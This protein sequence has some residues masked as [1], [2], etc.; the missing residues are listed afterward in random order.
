MRPA[1]HSRHAKDLELS[2]DGKSVARDSSDLARILVRMYH[3]GALR[4]LA[5]GCGLPLF[6]SVLFICP[7]NWAIGPGQ[8]LVIT[9]RITS[10]V[11]LLPYSAPIHRCRG[12]HRRG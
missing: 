10:G 11:T 8:G 2:S 4:A 1:L 3:A 9:L 7:R 6:A 5:A 12:S